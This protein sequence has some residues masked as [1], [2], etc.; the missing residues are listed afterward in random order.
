MMHMRTTTTLLVAGMA[1]ALLGC[2]D[3]KAALIGTWKARPI[4]NKPSNNFRDVAER[5]MMSLFGQ[6]M[7]IEF[8]R[9]GKFKMSMFMGEGRGNYKWEGDRIKLE[10]ETLAPSQPIYFRFAPDGK[11]LELDREFSSDA[12][13]VLDK[14]T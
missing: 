8:N 12:K 9:E 3:K 4:E 1:L 14:Q 2:Q 13:I 6:G 10:F 7:T 5:S 11:S